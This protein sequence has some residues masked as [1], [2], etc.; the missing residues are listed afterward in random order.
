[1]SDLSRR[2]LDVLPAR[3]LE[4]YAFLSVV[5]VRETRQIETAC[6][7]CAQSPELLLNPDFVAEHCRTDEHLFMLVMHELH[8]VVLGH[9]RL[10]P[11][12]TPARNVVFD[13]V[14]NA[15][16]CRRFP[17]P[18]FT[19]FLTD[20][21]PA[22]RMPFA[23]LRPPGPGTPEAAKPAL[24]ILYGDHAR[25][26]TYHDVWL[27]L[28]D[29][30][31]AAALAG[32]GAP[33]A[34]GAPGE[35]VLLGSHAA[36]GGGEP[37]DPAEQPG[38]AILSELLT[39]MLAKWPAPDRPLAGR[40]RGAA[41]RERAFDGP[42]APDA[43]LRR[44]V[45]R[46][47]RRALESGPAEARRRGACVRPVAVQTVLPTLADRSHAAREAVRGV[48]LLWRAEPPAPRPAPRTNRR[49]FAYLDVSGSVAARVPAAAA[50][51]EPWVRAGRCRLHV[52]ST[53]V[54]PATPDDLRR[55]AFASTGGTDID[56]V[57]EH[58]L[59][60]PPRERPHGIVL[61]TD[62]YVG[63]PDPALLARLRAARI[64]LH[65]GLLGT[66]EAASHDPAADLRSAAS[67]ILP[68]S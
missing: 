59:S 51:L 17:Q 44:G 39:E 38:G 66:D 14:I 20:Y 30:L 62:G 29:S 57:L 61:V 55:R 1:M 11:R 67:S 68:L 7:T 22:G 31:P 26:A 12:A 5:R 50:V 54:H 19:S 46:L 16:I 24:D 27:A 36:P 41:D 25:F 43:T 18:E 6:I 49:A 21:Y 32:P 28:L 48:E 63:R 37:E 33:D 4:L 3:S 64:R 65:V 40:D 47:M 35:P 56:C 42:D 2:I 60:L 8:H 9:T 34:P 52:F 23:L 15:M 13:A 10:F 53:V 58:V 45:R